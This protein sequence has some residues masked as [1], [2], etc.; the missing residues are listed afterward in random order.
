ME[1]KTYL[2]QNGTKW[3]TVSLPEYAVYISMLAIWSLRQKQKARQKIENHFVGMQKNQLRQISLKEILDIHQ[4]IYIGFLF[5]L[6]NNE[7]YNQQNT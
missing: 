1:G 5:W 6:R 3:W 2:W 4:S 7:R